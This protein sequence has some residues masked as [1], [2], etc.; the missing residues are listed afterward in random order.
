VSTPPRTF[1]DDILHHALT[2]PEKPAIILADRVATYG[3]MAQGMLCVEQRLRALALERSELVSVA[4]ENPIRHMIVASA[5]FR[6]GH[7]IISAVKTADLVRYKLPV[8]T[9]LQGEPEALVPGLKQI[10]V[11]E[12]W[13]TGEPQPIP[14][15]RVS[16][17]ADEQE[18]C[19]VDLSSGTTGRPKALSL[20][21][22]AFYQWTLNYYTAIGLGT[23]DRLVCLPGLNSS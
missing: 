5:L 17:F 6:L 23:W 16:G 18:V 9:F 1:A 12:D 19:R 11:G 8:R 10:V 7:P 2:R 21:L 4:I 15:V 20:S 14:A 13:F 22:K 3:M